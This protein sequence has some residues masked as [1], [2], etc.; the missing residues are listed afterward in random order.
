MRATKLRRS[1]ALDEQTIKPAL[2]SVDTDLIRKYF[3]RIREYVRWY[4]EGFATGP[5]IEKA[6]KLYRCWYLSHDFNQK[7]YI[8]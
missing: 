3:R 2:E 6:I 5:E 4:R 8:M 1:H 7:I